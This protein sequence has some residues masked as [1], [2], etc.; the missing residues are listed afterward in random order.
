M[1]VLDAVA[2]D[3]KDEQSMIIWKIGFTLDFEFLSLIPLL[4]V[5]PVPH[6]HKTPRWWTL[7]LDKY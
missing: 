7:T 5:A 6:V 1:S 3:S 2:K 4:G